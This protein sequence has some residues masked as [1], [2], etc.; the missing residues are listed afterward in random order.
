MIKKLNMRLRKSKQPLNGQHQ[1]RYANVFVFV[2]LLCST[3]SHG[4]ALNNNWEKDLSKSLE[5]FIKCAKSSGDKATCGATVGQ[6]LA[7]VYKQD[8]FF[9]PK[10]NRFLISNEISEIVEDS[11]RW[12]LLGFAYDQKVLDQAQQM[13]NTNKPV[14]AVYRMNGSSHVVLILPGA[15]HFS[16]SWGFKVPNSASFSYIDPDKSYVG[17]GL[18]YGFAKSMMKDITLYQMT[19]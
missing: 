9:S 8:A 18:S 17:K 3:I 1:Y 4:Q 19:Y 16:G 5:E 12:K 13:A 6:S 15:L 14:I 10:L 2:Y 7:T 11:K